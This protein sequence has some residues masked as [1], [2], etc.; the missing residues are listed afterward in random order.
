MHRLRNRIAVIGAATLSLAALTGC[1]GSAG[2][3]STSD[4]LAPLI[5]T[6]V[7]PVSP[8]TSASGVAALTN[9]TDA[10]PAA[11]A[12]QTS[13]SDPSG[14]ELATNSSGASSYTV[15]A[16]D[17]VF[18]I[19]K[20]YGVVPQA[21]ADF[22]E[23]TEGIDHPIFPGD[24]IKIPGGGSQQTPVAT[25]SATATV[26]PSTQ[27]SATTDQPATSTAGE[28][29]PTYVIVAGDFLAAIA[30]RFGTSVQAIIDANGWTD[31][32]DH[33]IIPGQSITLPRGD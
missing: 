27:P 23:W 29:G 24:V 20:S 12:G 26:T 25:T 9:P 10:S 17:T 6:N 7:V 32:V 11:T 18:R 15:V 28:P 33:L 30:A 2:S 19:A 4:T 5:P 8:V 21:L 16:N 3:S 22:N 14:T 13:P 1:I 31:G